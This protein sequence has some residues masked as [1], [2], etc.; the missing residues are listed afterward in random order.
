VKREVAL[1]RRQADST[2]AV[3][4]EFKSP[5]TSLR[6]LMERLSSG[7]ASG[8]SLAE[9][10]DAMA[11]ETDRLEGLVN[12]LLDVQQ[13]Q[14]GARRHAAARA[15]VGPL[16][17]AAVDRF[18]DQAAARQIGLTVDLPATMPETLVDTTSLSD[19]LD[20]LI[21]NALKYSPRGTAVSVCGRAVDG[22]IEIEVRDQGVGIDRDD[23]PH[24]FEPYYRGRLGDRESVRGTGLGLSLVQAAALA[25]GGRVDVTS[26]P[27]EG[28]AFTLRLPIEAHP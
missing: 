25:H 2:A 19:A 10:H 15:A 13:I 3:T 14:A 20:N 26:T 1:A 4:H 21:D 28:S 6:L 23:L 5:I 16:V 27:G 24:V 12:R 22:A 8:A 9:Y 11:R 18:R 7:R 17:F